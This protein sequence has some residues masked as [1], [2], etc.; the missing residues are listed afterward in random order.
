VLGIKKEPETIYLLQGRVFPDYDEREL[1][2]SDQLV[3]KS[4][5]NACGISSQEIV[6]NF[7]KLGDLGK[8]AEAVMKIKK[9]STLFS[10]KLTT[11]KVLENLRKLPTLEGKGTV[12]KKI[13]L[14]VELLNSASSAES[15]YVVRTNL[16]DLKVGVG[17]GLI[18]ALLHAV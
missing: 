10:K 15:K 4:I 7:K 17:N 11:E 12:E 13:A 5:A 3:I 6:E 2:I 8:A 16:G 18:A 1:G 14:V 9:Q